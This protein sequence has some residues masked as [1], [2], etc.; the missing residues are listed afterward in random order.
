MSSRTPPVT[1]DGNPN[2]VLVWPD[3]RNAP[4]AVPVD[5]YRVRAAPL[6]PMGDEAWLAVHREAIPGF[7]EPEYRTWLARY[8]ALALP[9]GILLAHDPA[10]DPVATAGAIAHDAGGL[11]PGGGQV[12]WVATVPRHRGRGFATWLSALVTARLLDEGYPTVAVVTGDDL[13]PA[14]R[15]YR[16][17]GFVPYL[18]ALDQPRR[19][20]HICSAAGL[21]FAPHRWPIHPGLSV[22]AA[23]RAPA[24]S[25]AGSGED[26]VDEDGARL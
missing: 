14:I 8:R 20:E 4:V 1:A 16:S 12:A 26:E 15:I 18:Y 7:R 2:I 5:G 10:G 9:G 23:R 17:I 6:G 19:W 13:I 11:F 25:I 21:E 22:P 3:G 24:A